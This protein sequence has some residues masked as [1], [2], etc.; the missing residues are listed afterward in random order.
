MSDAGNMLV[1]FTP[2]PDNGSS[3][4]N[5]AKAFHTLTLKQQKEFADELEEKE[6]QDFHAV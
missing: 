5:V 3:P 6:E 2:M 1:D 4:Q